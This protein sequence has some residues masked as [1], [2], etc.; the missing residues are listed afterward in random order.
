MTGAT[1]TAGDGRRLPRISPRRGWAAIGALG[2]AAL[3]GFFWD[4]RLK[5]APHAGYAPSDA[6]VVLVSADGPAFWSA[7]ENSPA[8]H[9]FDAQAPFLHAHLEVWLRRET[10]I[11]WTPARW[12]AWFGAS[13][14][15]AAEDGGWVVCVRPGILARGALRVGGWFD[16]APP[17]AWRDGFLLIAD[18]EGTLDDLSAFR[19]HALPPETGPVMRIAWREA[20]AGEMRVEWAGTLRVSG[21]VALAEAPGGAR[22]VLLDD[23]APE[24][25]GLLSSAGGPELY[26]RIRERV[27]DVEGDSIPGTVLEHVRGWIPESWPEHRG[28]FAFALFD[29]DTSEPAWVPEVALALGTVEGGGELSMPRDGIPYRWS[30]VDG[31]MRPWLGMDMS[32]YVAGTDRVRVYT[33]QEGTMSRVWSGNE[34]ILEPA[35]QFRFALNFDRIGP[36]AAGALR[37]AARNQLVPRHSPTDVERELVPVANAVG[38][39]GTL[40][41]DGVFEGN[42][43]MFEGGLASVPERDS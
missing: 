7:I 1:D 31:W 3:A 37:T 18:S 14:L 11:R 13:F 5:R 8:F 25:I 41:L 43:L 23:V 40:R 26:A 10:G 2:V 17:H 20:P 35:S 34:G 16:T 4:A 12:R 9:A 42:V 39:L 28:G 38:T 19:R 21:R 36:V 6:E 22:P 15:A 32:Q 33:N 29:I 30:G 24:A 27:L